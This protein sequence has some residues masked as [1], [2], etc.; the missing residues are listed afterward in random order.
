V[1]P[2]LDLSASIYNLFNG[3]SFD[4]GGP[5]NVQAKIEQDGISFLVKLTYRF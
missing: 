1:A 2:G 4:S 5:K 3:R